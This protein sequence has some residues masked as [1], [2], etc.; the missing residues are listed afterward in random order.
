M[1]GGFR[2]CAGWPLFPNVREY[3]LG[4][5]SNMGD[6]HPWPQRGPWLRSRPSLSGIHHTLAWYL[7]L[8]GLHGDTLGDEGGAGHPRL[9][10][11]NLAL[12]RVYKGEDTSSSRL[13]V[14]FPPQGSEPCAD[15]FRMNI[16]SKGATFTK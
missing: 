5:E 15:E 14:G 10:I 9:K 6:A 1:R 13:L 3:L 16:G 7:P 11:Q 4:A 2:P 8:R 12:P